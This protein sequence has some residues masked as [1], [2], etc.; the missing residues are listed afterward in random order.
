MP[1]GQVIGNPLEQGQFGVVRIAFQRPEQ[2]R[3]GEFRLPRLQKG[4]RQPDLSALSVAGPH[5][6][7]I[8]AD[9]SLVD[10]THLKQNI[11]GGDQR[12]RFL[13]GHIG[14]PSVDADRVREIAS[15]PRRCPDPHQHRIVQ[16]RAAA[17]AAIDS[18]WIEMHRRCHASRQTQDSRKREEN[19]RPLGSSH[20]GFPAPAHIVTGRH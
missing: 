19:A 7:L 20:S 17:V 9:D 12:G 14:R 5:Q 15:G 11:A 8:V 6:C 10:G 3:L 4:L 13:R 1:T 2:W 18:A 16:R